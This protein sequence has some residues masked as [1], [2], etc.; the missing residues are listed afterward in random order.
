MASLT[1][2][3]LDVVIAWHDVISAKYLAADIEEEDP[4][5]GDDDFY[6]IAMLPI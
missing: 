5:A 1:D 6:Y 2:R 4:Y 3:F